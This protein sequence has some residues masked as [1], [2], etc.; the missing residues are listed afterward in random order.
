MPW[1]ARTVAAKIF[2]RCASAFLR[3]PEHDFA[4][5]QNLLEIR[6]INHEKQDER[7]ARIFCTARGICNGAPAFGRLIDD[8][9]KLAAVTDFPA[10]SF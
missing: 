9:K 2:Q 7:A 1:A 4:D 5:T 6:V 8:G 3:F 10:K